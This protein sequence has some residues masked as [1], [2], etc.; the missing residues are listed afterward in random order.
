MIKNILYNIN[1]NRLF[2]SVL[3]LFAFTNGFSQCPTVVNASQTFCNTQSPT[4]ANLV[5]TDNGNGVVWYATATS[6]TPLSSS[7]GLVN[8]AHYFADDNSGSCGSRQE[9][10]V[11]IYLAPTGQN[12]QGV[13]VDNAS[14]ATIGS[15]I[16]VGNNIQWYTTPSGGSALA[17]TTILNNNT[18]YYASQ[19]NPVT[20]CQT[21]RLSVFVTVGVVP[22]PTGNAVQFFCNDPSNPPTIND[23]VASG[24]NNWY[25]TSSSSVPLDVTTPLVNGQS[26]F[27]TTIS[28][29]CESIDRLEVVATLLAPNNAGSNGTIKVCSNQ[30]SGNP[31]RNLF[32]SLGG[33][34]DATGIWTGPIAT[35]NGNL[36]TVDIS[37]MTA[38]GSP[39][40]FTYTVSNAAC[41]P[42]SSTVTITISNPKNAG[43]STTLTVCS[44]APSQNLFTLLGGSAQVGGTW[45]PALA[46]GTGVFNPA[47]DASGVYTYTISDI[48]PCGNA[49]ATV[50]VTVVPKA[51]AGTNGSLT[52]CAND[53]SQ[54]LFTSLGGTPQAGG[55]WSPALASGTGVFNPAVDPAGVYTYTVIGTPPCSNA[56]ATVT[57]TVNPNITPTFT[58]LGPYCQNTVPG[59]LPTTS[60]NGYTG[61]WSPSTI[62]TAT[63]GTQVYTFTPTAGPCTTIATMSI[64][65]TAPIVPT[66]TALGPYCQNALPGSLPTTSSNGYTGTWSP[67]TI[68]TTTVGTQVYTFTPTAGQ[69]VAIATMSVT[70][71]APIVPTF[72]ELGP[73]C[74][75]DI[76][77]SL[78]TTSLNGFTGTWSPSTISTAAV[79]TQVYTFTPTAG[80]C[81]TTTTMSVT[82]TA[83]IVP[84]FTALGPYCQNDVPGSL[85]TTSINGYTGTW[86][87]STIST[88][89][90]GTQV[91]TF[92]PTAGQ[93]VS[94]ATMSVTITAPIVPTFTALGPYCQNAIPSALP[95][96]SNNGYT[97]TWSPSTIDTTTV[98]TQIYT[99]TPTAGQ[100]VTTAIMS[101]TITAP[102]VPTFVALG[103]Y[104]QNAVPGSL[105][106]TS[107]NGITGTWSPSTISTATV[108]TQVYTFTPTAGLCA[109]PTTMSVTITTPVVPT[110]TAL[111]PY[112]QNAVPGSLPT[113]STNG[114]TGTWSPSTVSTTTVGTQ[115]YT[116]T[117]TVGLCATTAT[118]SVT[119]TAPIV[120]TFTALGSYCQNDLPGNLP[121]TSINGFTGTW[122]PATISTATVGTQVYTFTPTAGLCATTATMSITITAPIVPTFTALGPYCQ[123]A[124]PGSLPTTSTNG[125][126]GTWSPSTIDTTTVGTQVYTFTPTAGLC[127]AI[128]TMS[129]TI[130]APIVPTFT[131]L[132]PYC[133]NA[134]PDVLPTTS[135]NGYTGTWSPTTIDTTTVG[136]QVYTF[137]P[138]AGQ[139]VAIATLSI[140]ITAPIVPTFTALGP[141]CQ[142]AIPDVL[143]TT[144]S[145]GITGTWSPSIIDSTTVGTQVYTF[146]PTAGL[147][148]TTATMS[149]TITAPIIPTFTALGPYCQNATP[150]VL[151]T[152]SNNGITGAWTPATIS[153]T[154]VGTQVYTFTPTAGLCAITATM[155]IT[156]TAPILPTF[157][158]LGPYCQND[159][160]GTLP[161]TSL[162]GYTGSW[163]PSTISTATV[164]TQI[165][166]FTPTAGQCVTIAT[167][168][169]TINGIVPTFTAL[170]PYCQNATPNALPTTSNNGIAGTWSPST[171][172]TTTV[173]TQVYTF[174][175]TAGQC[176]TTA[177]MSVTIT[178][179]IVP[180]FSNFGPYCQNAVP[181][182]LP[183]TSN[184]GI[185]GTWLPATIDTTT[186]GIQ[187][188][189]FTPTTGLCATTA[190][191]S[192][193]ITAPLVPTFTALGP[194]CQNAIPAVLPSTS[195]NGITGT[196]SPSTIDS[197]T[198]GTQVYTFTPTAL[199]CATTTTMS[200]TVTAPIVPTFTALGPYCQ[201]AVADVLPTTS[202]NGITGTWLPATISTATVGTQVYT[203]TPTAGLCATT[204]T[205]SITITA[206]IVPTF[207]ALGPY[208]QNDVPGSLPTTSDNGYSGTWSPSTISTAT[209]GTQVYTFT[210]TAGLCVTTTT[211]SITVTGTVPT[212]TA[213]GPYCQNATADALP[214]ISGNGITGAWLPA[215][216]DTTI[217]GTQ[218]YTFTP[219]AGQCAT[220]AT[221]SVTITVP[222]IPTFPALGPYCQNATPDALPTTS[223]NGIT[224]TWSPST[225]VTDTVGTQVYTFTPTTGLCATTTTM[226]VVI[227][228]PTVPTFTGLGPYCQNATPDVLP[229]TSSNGITGSWSP[230][231]ITTA[232]VGTQSY[233]FTPTA[234]QCATP[235]TIN[236]IV[237]ALTVPTFTALGS[238]CQNATPDAL[239]TTSVNGITGIWSPSTISTAT[240]GT[241]VYTFTPTTGLCATTF[242]MSVIINAPTVPTFTALG[243]YCQNA[244]PDALPTTSINGV[245]G[246]W[247]PATISTAIVGTQTYTFTPTT[248]LCATTAIM[249]VTITGTV[250]TFT[251]VG[252]YCQNAT[253]DALP[254]TSTNGGITGTW[255]PA[256]ISTTIV[257]TQVYTF[258]PAG[259]QC[260]TTTT[261][262][263]TIT[264]PV[265]PTFTALGP[266]CQN[267]TP[268]ALPTASAN[269]GIT[270]TWSPAVISTATLGTQ[271][272]T[273]TPTAGQCAT[274]TTMSITINPVA[275]AGTSGTLTICNNPTPQDL[276]L[277]LGGTPQTGGVWTPTLHSGTGIFDPA[278]DAA[279]IYTYTI[280]S[281]CSPVSASVTVAICPTVDIIVP[282]GFSPNGDGINDEFVVKN[283]ADLY[284]NFT[285]EIYNRYGSI[286]YKG[287]INTPNWN[288]KS[289]EGLTI[290][291]GLLPTGVYFFIIE[292]NDGNRKALQGR[293]YLSR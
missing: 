261:M 292:F 137:T 41:T 208:C 15:L 222:T 285:L 163:S 157:T 56:S 227:N 49:T 193:T 132:G 96:T 102:I 174:T 32:N 6:T 77:G 212:F 55:T 230:S 108:G 104:C 99:F 139:C 173:G 50:T 243:S 125:Y 142:N 290:G 64:T 134:T 20:G 54:N 206:P 263:V 30:I 217:V 7:A 275:D 14:Q 131:A 76:P 240:V 110:F 253:T 95:T 247:S 3:L 237:N 185:T 187:N 23:L 40:V 117:P 115:I 78:P 171:I 5:A 103:P 152:I 97:G 158:V 196:W 111:G 249:N 233:T 279:G 149:V 145:N 189:T 170:G 79:G 13:C 254:A 205:M 86:S 128:A 267:M 120:P 33:T 216:I 144:S 245:T 172:A 181:D 190:T 179:P 242:A 280:T 184:N 39:Y 26:Y 166:T 12:F 118:M 138:T 282:D 70:I 116:F 256:V 121:T 201:N 156:I 28:P 274:T 213:L 178:A 258:T 66:F 34:P 47:V 75:N 19:T 69:C 89:T 17:S 101:V 141:Y 177:T 211:M 27:A 225:I 202:G 150:D 268:D 43:T 81:A 11:T 151:P 269:G 36:G 191:L 88:A 124:I 161:T 271:V 195:S 236:V 260:A 248:G 169:I 200:I 218:T 126:T 73:Y 90:V 226:S 234:G 63:V 228:A 60:I 244:T 182:T 251:A 210:P 130:T 8:G 146:T 223:V 155:S 87:P 71:T 265:L 148:A 293:V 57:V 276:F 112:C 175:P 238:Y 94:I 80:Q 133:Q 273:F 286:L 203:F 114:I 51:D 113:T 2:I 109:T 220:T 93:C 224:G 135:N 62:S 105:P 83:P 241:Q 84:T 100:C 176:A 160:P 281:A 16:A 1:F 61:T 229:T 272:Y 92:T 91:Y 119:I 221:M 37:T 250:P 67:S 21:S 168:S 136:T 270:G 107:S 82:I 262:S 239:P 289:S 291:D 232:T 159:I 214:A 59:S 72:T 65:I 123:N 215:T 106:T 167:M 180:V 231:A 140:T 288:G 186:V 154:T 198:V 98:G 22:V 165:Y 31:I 42:S 45:S 74:Q 264:A 38:A 129:V 24:V 209:V 164:G 25:A 277:S 153:T 122:S 58:A 252:P 197:T 219:T 9:V 192:I 199:L 52:L 255:S 44:N 188:Y 46:S 287:N 204:T 68:S 35:T 10:T 85:P 147:C 283:L 259:G 127:V 284:P 257:G 207:T 162:N 18:I 143:P 235:T 246:T 53:P 48:A 266:Y 4:V 183:A 29:P 278:F 194:Y